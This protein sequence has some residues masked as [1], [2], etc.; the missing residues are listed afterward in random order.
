MRLFESRFYYILVLLSLL[1]LSAGNVIAVEIDTLS[2]KDNETIKIDSIRVEGNDITQ[3]FIILRELTFKEGDTVTGKTLRYNRERVFSLQLFSQIVFTIKEIEKQNILIIRLY[4][5]WYIY[6]IPFVRMQDGNLKQ[7]TY[8]ASILWRN[9]R[10]RDEVLRTNLGFGY[11]SFYSLLYQN[12]ALDHENSIGLQLF[13][14]YAEPT[15]KSLIAQSIVGY[16]YRNNVYSNSVSVGK[17]L[18]QFSLINVSAGFDYI[19]APIAQ[20][21]ITASGGR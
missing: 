7:G 6:P 21:G 11:N 13:F 9:F 19:E 18:N 12:P 17:R 16:E 15:I 2:L 14:A 20:S 10:G 1:T 4:E 3:K 5:S 8:G